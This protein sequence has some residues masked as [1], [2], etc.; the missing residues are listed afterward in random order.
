M[1]QEANATEG[2]RRGEQEEEL[3]L[4]RLGTVVVLVADR[5]EEDEQQKQQQQ[6]VREIMQFGV[7]L[8]KE[9]WEEQWE[10]Q[11]AVIMKNRIA[12][13]DQQDQA[14]QVEEVVHRELVREWPEVLLR[15]PTE[16]V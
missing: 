1:K 3:D 9:W 12:L 2:R 6:Q 16:S 11:E 15:K 5:L 13:A 7:E 4:E 8:E 14:F 10:R